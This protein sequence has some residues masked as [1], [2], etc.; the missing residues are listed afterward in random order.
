MRLYDDV[1]RQKQKDE[2]S[3]SKFTTG[4]LVMMIGLIFVTTVF[5]GESVNS[6][7]LEKYH[8]ITIQS[9]DTLWEIA[10]EYVSPEEDIRNLILQ[11]KRINDLKSAEILPGQTILIPTS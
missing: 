6:N 2:K 11:I 4:I 7:D 9:G 1:H 8:E 5:T 10:K 3:N